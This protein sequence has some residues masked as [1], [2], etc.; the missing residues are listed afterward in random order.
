MGSKST[1]KNALLQQLI[2]YSTKATT[3]IPGYVVQA[4]KT[5]LVIVFEAFAP[6][7]QRK[8]FVARKIS[9]RN[10]TVS[11]PRGESV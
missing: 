10:N 9:W 2:T 6:I 7:L 8:I 4:C 1:N 3:V 11:V 5:R